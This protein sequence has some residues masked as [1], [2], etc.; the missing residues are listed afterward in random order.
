MRYLD[1]KSF[2]ILSATNVFTP[3]SVGGIN[4][5]YSIN[6]QQSLDVVAHGVAAFDDSPFVAAP[7]LFSFPRHQLFLDR[8]L[9]L[10]WLLTAGFDAIAWALAGVIRSICK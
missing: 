9:F 3:F 10:R 8:S 5:G 1:G 7:S 6:D 2:A 4:P